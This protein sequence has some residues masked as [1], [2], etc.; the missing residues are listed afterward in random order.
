MIN[1]SFFLLRNELIMHFGTNKIII[2]NNNNL[3]KITFHWEIEEQIQGHDIISLSLSLLIKDISTFIII[4]IIG[5][6]IIIIIIKK[7]EQ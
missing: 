5:I 1:V 4:I 3:M 6:I 7:Q 2:V